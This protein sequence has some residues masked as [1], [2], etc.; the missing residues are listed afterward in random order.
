M[1]IHSILALTDFSTPAEHALDRA[2]LLAV[3]HRAR[4]RIMYA[5]EVPNLRFSDPFAR[6]QQRAR[7][8]ARR[9]GIAAEAL[10]HSGG[11]VDAIVRHAARADLLVLDPRHHR[12]AYAF[13]RGTTLDQL[14]RRCPCPV[15]VV[16]Q[17]PSRPY[18]HLLVAVDFTPESKKLVRYASG[19]EGESALELFH[20]FNTFDESGV[21]SDAGSTEAMQAY[22]QAVLQDTQNRLIQFS[23]SLDTRRNRASVADGFAEPARQIAV[24]QDF[25]RSDLVI[26]GKRRDSTLVDFVFGSVARRVVSLVG[27]DVLVVSHDY[28]APSGAAAKR[29]M[30][31]LLQIEASQLQL[32]SR[33]AV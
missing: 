4:L 2:A 24:H 17:A 11:M 9:H 21:R 7:Q 3:R 23:D 30:Q 27:C 22:R 13:W 8:L 20:A 1:R 33:R 6:L 14:M 32:V 15:L 10:A 5:D 29:R 19:F 12:V 26:V 16:K 25:V 18:R 28:Q 31:S